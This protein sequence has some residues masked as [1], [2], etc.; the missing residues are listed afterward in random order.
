M[1]AKGQKQT[2]AP[3]TRG[4]FFLPAGTKQSRS[5]S[6]VGLGAQQ[7]CSEITVHCWTLGLCPACGSAA[8][9]TDRAQVKN[10]SAE[11]RSPFA[12]ALRLWFQTSSAS[13]SLVWRVPIVKEA[14]LI[15]L[16]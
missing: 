12:A 15:A 3:Q 16:M 1:S 14:P 5:C 11:I 10:G 7:C 4:L 6:C 8:D 9:V 13:F 2:F